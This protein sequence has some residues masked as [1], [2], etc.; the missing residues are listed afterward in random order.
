ML[1]DWRQRSVS[2]ATR[3]FC[4]ACVQRVRAI[5]FRDFVL[6]W[7]EDARERGEAPLATATLARYMS[8]VLHVS[9]AAGNLWSM[10]ESMSADT[11][12]YAP[13]EVKAD[14]VDGLIVVYGGPRQV[15]P[16]PLAEQ[17]GV[18]DGWRV[19]LN[20]VCSFGVRHPCPAS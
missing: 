6:Y 8:A 15:Q 1:L 13:E 12:L 17:V 11:F 20:P 3:Q 16:Y 9:M 5:R 2:A 14:A 18:P 19:H 10:L 7:S 4:E